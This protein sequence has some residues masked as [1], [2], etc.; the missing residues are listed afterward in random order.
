MTE[1][2]KNYKENPLNKDKV[3]PWDFNYYMRA[4]K[5]VT[6]DLNM[7]EIKKYFPLPK[8]TE[9]LFQIY[10]TLLGLIFEEVETDNKWHESV[11]LYS[12]KDKETK[13]IIGYFYFDLFPRDGKYSHA[14][15]FDFWTGCDTSKF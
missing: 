12:V 6:C 14:A 4:Y 3:E 5:E 1:F 13:N 15:C 9:G 2:A 11:K 7:E 8:V 10:Q